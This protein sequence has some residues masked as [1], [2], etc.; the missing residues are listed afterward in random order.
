MEEKLTSDKHFEPGKQGTQAPFIRPWYTL[1]INYGTF[2]N[3][4]S[5]REYGVL[6]DFSRRWSSGMVG[7]GFARK[8]LF[9]FTTP[10]VSDNPYRLKNSNSRNRSS[11]T[12]LFAWPKDSIVQGRSYRRHFVFR[13][14]SEIASHSVNVRGR[15]KVLESCLVLPPFQHAKKLLLAAQILQFSS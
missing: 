14:Q 1:S 15:R 3:M 5:D 13:I 9:S 7:K 2:T 6:I 10:V 4:T 11:P 12:L 8:P